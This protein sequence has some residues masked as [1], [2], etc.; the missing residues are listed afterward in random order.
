MRFSSLGNYVNA[1][2]MNAA[3]AGARFARLGTVTLSRGFRSQCLD[4]QRSPGTIT[5]H[6]ETHGCTQ[7]TVPL[8]AWAFGAE[9]IEGHC[10][11]HCTNDVRR[12]LGPRLSAHPR[13]RGD[14]S[15]LCA[16]NCCAAAMSAKDFAPGRCSLSCMRYT[17]SGAA[18]CQNLMRDWH[19][20]IA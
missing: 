15:S 7:A 16:L 8:H 13:A 4:G 3:A 10:R 18:T 2:F 20:H 9:V 12:R 17:S 19:A 5:G 14:W 6:Q 1:L 11:G